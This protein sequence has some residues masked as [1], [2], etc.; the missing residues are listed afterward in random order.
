MT[1][2]IINRG[3]GP[4]IAET[5]ITLL[6]IIPY[7]EEGFSEAEIRDILGL[8]LDQLCAALAYLKENRAT[9]MEE[10]RKVE[11]RL[12][13][14]NPPEIEEKLAQ[15]TRR[16]AKF[17]EWFEQRGSNGSENGSLGTSSREAL[18]QQ[19]KNWLQVRE[20]AGDSES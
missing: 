7:I 10:H 14:G 15:S 18:L 16:F 12:A 3:R 9:L 13:R 17:K 2:Q 8:S 11:E 1:T 20:S 19:F 6:N 4:E 5:R